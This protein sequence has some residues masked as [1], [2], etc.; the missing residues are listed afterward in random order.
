MNDSHISDVNI[1]P[2]LADELEQIL[3]HW[4]YELDDFSSTS[5]KMPS[6]EPYT[7]DYGEN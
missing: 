4:H 2:D 1:A 6:L 5:I 3:I 7:A